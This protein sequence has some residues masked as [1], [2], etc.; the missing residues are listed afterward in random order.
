[1]RRGYL[2]LSDDF[3]SLSKPTAWHKHT[4]YSRTLWTGGCAGT[5]LPAAA[6]S[7]TGRQQQQ[8]ASAAAQL[9]EQHHE[10]RHAKF[11]EAADDLGAVFADGDD[12]PDPTEAAAHSTASG[13]GSIPGAGRSFS[14]L[15]RPGTARSRPG[16]AAGG[17]GGGGGGGGLAAWAGSAAARRI[18][19]R[20]T[21][22][23]LGSNPLGLAGAKLIAEV[24][25]LMRCDI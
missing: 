3:Q 22:L 15:S 4:N 14:A 23:D 21:D 19:S 13:A 9:H 16:S 12:Q 17:G 6:L 5:G 25:A 8:E 10:Q 7:A 18:Y 20:L 2:N 24:R 11:A 1:M